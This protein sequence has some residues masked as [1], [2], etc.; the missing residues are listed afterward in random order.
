[1]TSPLLIQKPMSKESDRGML[2]G[3]ESMAA[4]QL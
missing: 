3:L 1:L 2:A 4:M